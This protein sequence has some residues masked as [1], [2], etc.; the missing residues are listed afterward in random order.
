M[1]QN[2]VSKETENYGPLR[3][4]VLAPYFSPHQT[5][6]RLVSL[7]DFWGKSGMLA[8]YPADWS[9]VCG[10]ELALFNELSST[11]NYLGASL[12]GISVDSPWS[13]AAFAAERKI[14]FSLLSDFEPKGE[15]ARQYGVYRD[16]DGITELAL[17]VIDGAAREPAE[18]E[19]GSG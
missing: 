10:S 4:G 12:P 19:D 6:D 15:V 2:K 8:F 11:F 17:F 7:Q 9:P 16:I 18:S 1:L 5:P 13:Q 3:P 14:K